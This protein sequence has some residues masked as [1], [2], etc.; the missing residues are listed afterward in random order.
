M[1]NGLLVMLLL[2]LFNYVPSWAA[3]PEREVQVGINGV[4]VPSKI[5]RRDEAVVV[6]NGIFQNGCYRWKKSDV[7]H[8]AMTTHEVRSFA[9]VSQG[10]CLM[11]LVP[12]QK[13]V[14]LGKLNPGRHLV[15]FVN[16]DGTY[17]D[18]YL[19]VD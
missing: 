19:N 5:D 18:R 11:V 3:V 9:T 13:E 10:M 17:L 1:I 15:R 8:V 2:G 14:N 16:G 6:V 7:K 4:Y 12:F